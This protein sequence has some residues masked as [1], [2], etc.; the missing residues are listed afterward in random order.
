[1]IAKVKKHSSVVSIVR[2]LMIYFSC[3]VSTS[4][5]IVH[6]YLAL[7]ALRLYNSDVTLKCLTL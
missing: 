5:Q 2:C 1:M 3:L 4:S 7:I 6:L